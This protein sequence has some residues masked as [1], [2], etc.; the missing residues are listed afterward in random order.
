VHF[1]FLVR[2][3]F[4]SPPELHKIRQLIFTYYRPKTNGIIIIII[5]NIV[6]MMIIIVKKI[7]YI[8]V[9]VV[10]VVVFVLVVVVVAAAVVVVVIVAVVVVVVVHVLLRKFNEVSL[11]SPGSSQ[12]IPGS[13]F[14]CSFRNA[15]R[16]TRQKIFKIFRAIY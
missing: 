12:E 10:V 14:G 6:L 7:Y 9:E 8:R 16:E 4:L 11:D 2:N 5:I 15:I 13:S 1:T 3:L